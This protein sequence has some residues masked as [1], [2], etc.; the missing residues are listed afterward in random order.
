MVCALTFQRG[1]A[2]AE[3]AGSPFALVADSAAGVGPKEVEAEEL[4]AVSELGTTRSVAAQECSMEAQG[5]AGPFDPVQTSTGQSLTR[6]AM[7]LQ[8][9]S[10]VSQSTSER[11][12]SQN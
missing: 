11:R 4:A 1:V 5:W 9:C 10:F 3:K 6:K 12:S 8:D 7:S 2:A